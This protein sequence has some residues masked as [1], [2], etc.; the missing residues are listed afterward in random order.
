MTYILEY[1]I[2]FRRRRRKKHK[3]ALKRIVLGE[4][5]VG[6]HLVGKCVLASSNVC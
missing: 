4:T 1:I 5:K 6:E 3:F 2:Y